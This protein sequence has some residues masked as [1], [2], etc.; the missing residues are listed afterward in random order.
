[1]PD[2]LTDVAQFRTIGTT[3]TCISYSQERPSARQVICRE[4]ALLVGPGFFPP[5][6]AGYIMYQVHKR[7]R[8]DRLLQ[9]GVRCRTQS[10]NQTQERCCTFSI[11]GGQFASGLG[12]VPEAPFPS[13]ESGGVLRTCLLEVKQIFVE[14]DLR[15]RGLGKLLVDCMMQARLG[16]I[17]IVCSL[18]LPPHFLDAVHQSCFNRSTM[19]LL[20]HFKKSKTRIPTQPALAFSIRCHEIVIALKPLCPSHLWSV[21]NFCPSISIVDATQL[22]RMSSSKTEHNG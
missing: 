17:A 8:P 20:K 11:R 2:S 4:C 9:C 16:L 12:S 14:P 21:R 19:M 13:R 5:R 22:M 3:V 10:H 7:K 15:K 1:M 18:K 6:E